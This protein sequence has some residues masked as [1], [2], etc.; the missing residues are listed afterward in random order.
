MCEVAGGGGV[1]RKQD[2]AAFLSALARMER[3]RD[4]EDFDRN[5]RRFAGDV[6]DCLHKLF[7]HATGAEQENV[8]GGEYKDDTP[9]GKSR[10]VWGE[11]VPGECFVLVSKHIGSYTL[12]GRNGVVALIAFDD[13][14]R[15]GWDVFFGP[16]QTDK[17]F[18]TPDEA[19]KYALHA[20]NK[21]SGRAE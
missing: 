11:V 20:L 12:N 15:A 13:S 17:T 1:M 2:N 14:R 9:T 21:A 18:A 4:N 10:G 3:M 6:R 5:L 16:G 7:L 19:L 8:G